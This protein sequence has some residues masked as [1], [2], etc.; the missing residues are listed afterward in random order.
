MNAWVLLAANLLAL[1]SA[2]LALAL[3]GLVGWWAPL[4]VAAAIVATLWRFRVALESEL[5]QL[6]DAGD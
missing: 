5:E 1:A 6:R 3:A 2:S 4:T